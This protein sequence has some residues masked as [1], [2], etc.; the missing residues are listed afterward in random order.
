[1]NK[2][3]AGALV[4]CVMTVLC[5][6]AIAD[7]TVRVVWVCNINE[8]KTLDDVKAANSAWVRFMHGKVD[9]AIT[10]TILTPIVGNF[11]AG[12]FIFADDFPSMTVWNEAREASQTTEG[13]AIDAAI[14]AAVTCSS[15][16]MHSAEMS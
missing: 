11:E 14:N 5:A 4:T 8:G 6:T 13:Q 10:S 16:S 9:D 2:K 15:N 7:P 12:R 3:I 1:M